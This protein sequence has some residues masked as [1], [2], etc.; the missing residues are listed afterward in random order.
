MEDERNI[1]IYKTDDGKAN[2]V[3]MAKD[4]NIWMN[5]NQL[6]ELLTPLIGYD[7]CHF[8]QPANPKNIT[9]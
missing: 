1:I 9:S 8:M 7:F 6:T 5:Q 4:G 2:V 3:L